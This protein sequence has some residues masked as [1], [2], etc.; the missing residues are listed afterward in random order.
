MDEKIAKMWEG[1]SEDV[2]A[3]V[4]RAALQAEVSVPELVGRWIVEKAEVLAQA[5]KGG[6]KP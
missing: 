3:T 6:R 2:R 5:E 4:R 1:L